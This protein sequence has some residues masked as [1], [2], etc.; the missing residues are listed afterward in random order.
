MFAELEEALPQE[1]DARRLVVL[2]LR[3]YLLPM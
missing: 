3:L 2:C 1:W